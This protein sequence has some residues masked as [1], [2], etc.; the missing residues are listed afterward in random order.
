MSTQV[1]T[2]HVQPPAPPEP[3]R[4]HSF[5]REAFGI[6]GSVTLRVS[7]DVLIF[8]AI[9][10]VIYLLNYAIHPELGVDVTPF[11]VAGAALGLLLVLRTNAGYDRWWE[12]R[13]LWGGIVNQCRGLVSSAMSYG[14]DDPEWF[15]RLARWTI[16]F[17]HVS[18][19]SL[20]N[21]REIPEVAALL[22]PEAAAE[23]AA[24][25]H[26]PTAVHLR[27]GA[28]LR[29]GL[30][31]SGRDP[32]V[33]LPSEQ[34]RLKLIDHIGA[35][36][37]ILKS[38]LPRVYGIK[39]RRFIFLFLASLP[40]ALLDRLGWLTPFVT[41]LVAYPILSIDHIGVALQN[42]FNVREL[43]HLPLDDICATIEGDLLAMVSDSSLQGEAMD[44]DATLR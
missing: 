17:A 44:P 34:E 20:R 23:I 16:C 15:D 38:P 9:S 8:T 32:I 14:P 4:S 22:G 43:G 25:R 12:A 11:E 39:I 30:E 31:R 36:E 13:K 1:P 27:L 24:A 21:E 7:R 37:R 35:C 33:M 5:W 3:L 6:R 42:P 29:E 40:F 18:R 41:M 19:R 10:L 28:L 2:D 26:M